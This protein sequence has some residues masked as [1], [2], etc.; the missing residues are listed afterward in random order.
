M[1]LAQAPYLKTTKGYKEL[2]PNLLK[3]DNV[4]KYRWEPN[5][6]FTATFQ[7]TESLGSRVEVV[8]VN[9]KDVYCILNSYLV[10]L[11]QNSTIDQ[12]R[13]TGTWI[14]YKHGQAFG[15]KLA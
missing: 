5:E 7:I 2:A 10:E 1:P 3:Y 11:I 13:I 15:L 12:G 14:V 4:N 8:N 6:P 9:T